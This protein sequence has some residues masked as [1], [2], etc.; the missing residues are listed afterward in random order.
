MHS[1]VGL[2]VAGIL[3]QTI[4]LGASKFSTSHWRHN[5]DGVR[6]GYG[7]PWTPL[8][9]VSWKA[10]KS[11]IMLCPVQRLSFYFSNVVWLQPLGKL[12]K[13]KKTKQKKLQICWSLY[14]VLFFW[15][16]TPSLFLDYHFVLD[17]KGASI[18]TMAVSSAGHSVI[19][20]VLLGLRKY[21][22]TP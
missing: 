16:S 17:I 5:K 19:T 20:L 3:P 4:K 11:R 15:A 21:T 18:A 8:K 9:E 1:S 13:A 22:H 10:L 6:C 14:I 2:S 7:L 12:N